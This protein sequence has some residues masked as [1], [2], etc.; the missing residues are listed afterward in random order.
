MVLAIQQVRIEELIE[1]KLDHIIQALTLVYL[2]QVLI[3]EGEPVSQ[4]V[5][6]KEHLKVVLKITLKQRLLVI[7][8]LIHKQRHM[9]FLEV[10]S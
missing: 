10:F 7:L 4:Q 5:V 9:E 2:V 1:I 6:M 3:Q 8:K